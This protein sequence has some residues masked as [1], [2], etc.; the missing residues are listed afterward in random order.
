M[1]W[2][3][4]QIASS[5]P[6]LVLFQGPYD[7]VAPLVDVLAHHDLG[8]LGIAG[9]QRPSDLAVVVI[10]D[11]VLVRRVPVERLEDE[12]D[13]HGAPDDLLETP[14]A[15]G[16]GDGAVKLSVGADEPPDLLL[17]AR[18]LVPVLVLHLPGEPPKPVELVAPDPGRRPQRGVPLKD[19]PQIVDFPH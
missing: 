16:E 9:L 15:P 17:V 5:L 7:K 11:D 19:G 2:K 4:R 10:G 1:P 14:V 3:S 12:R 8:P 6:T 13:L 18:K